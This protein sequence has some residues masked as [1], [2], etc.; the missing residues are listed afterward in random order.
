MIPAKHLWF[1]STHGSEAMVAVLA[2]EP[3]A[4]NYTVAQINQKKAD[5]IKAKGAKR[6]LNVENIEN[7]ANKVGR[8]PKAM[9][10]HKA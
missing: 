5:L 4:D 2:D 7:V 8:P 1:Y 10:L 6:V 9:Q 3:D